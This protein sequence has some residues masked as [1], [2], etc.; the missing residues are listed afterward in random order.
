MT[1]F[2]GFKWNAVDNSNSVLTDYV[3]YP[4]LGVDEIIERIARLGASSGDGF[5]FDMATE[6]IVGAA[7]PTDE[8]PFIYLE[9]SEDGNP[10]RSFDIN[11]YPANLTLR[12]IESVAVKL[13]DFY[14]VARREFDLLYDQVGARPLGHLSAG[15]S[16]SGKNFFTVYYE[17][18]PHQ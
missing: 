9:A 6:I 5:V 2:Q 11:L 18:Q 13:F 3:C 14:G 1:M 15:I 7:G 4:L 10:R 17:N 16:R 8:Q 12:S